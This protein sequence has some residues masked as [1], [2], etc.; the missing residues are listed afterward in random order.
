[1]VIFKSESEM[2]LF[3]LFGLRAMPL[4]TCL[5]PQFFL[6]VFFFP[7]ASRVISLQNSSLTRSA[8]SLGLCAGQERRAQK[9]RSAAPESSVR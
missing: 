4:Y 9:G 1:M 3:M 7:S 6:C 8:G 5:Y 2:R